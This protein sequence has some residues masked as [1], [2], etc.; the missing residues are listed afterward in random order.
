MVAKK[1]IVQLRMEYLKPDPVQYKPYDIM[2]TSRA[3]EEVV[4]QFEVTAS[5]VLKSDKH[6]MVLTPEGLVEITTQL[7]K[8]IKLA[9]IEFKNWAVKQ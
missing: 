3:G 2:I 9:N 6:G 1:K 8:A 4:V 7:M 5:E